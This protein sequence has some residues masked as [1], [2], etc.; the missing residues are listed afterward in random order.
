MSKRN[1]FRGKLGYP[2]HR[3]ISIVTRFL[4]LV[5]EFAIVWFQ[6]ELVTQG[7]DFVGGVW[8]NHCDVFVL[9]IQAVKWAVYIISYTEKC[10]NT[11]DPLSLGMSLCAM[12]GSWWIGRWSQSRW[13]WFITG[14]RKMWPRKFSL[15]EYQLDPNYSREYWHTQ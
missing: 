11:W 15:H 9:F 13:W 7:E 1:F 12:V 4:L 14:T 6:N 5:M 8:M 10:Y 3:T 2:K